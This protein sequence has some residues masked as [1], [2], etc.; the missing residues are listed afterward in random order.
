MAFEDTY[1][2]RAQTLIRNP[3][4]GLR[5]ILPFAKSRL[6]PHYRRALERLGSYRL[7]KPYSNHEMLLRHI[8]RKGGFFVQC[9]GNDGYGNDPTYYLEK[10]LGWTGIIAE[11]LPIYRA[12]QANR[13][14]STVFNYATGSFDDAGK[15]VSFIDCYGMSFV[16]GS[17]ENEGEWTSA[18]ERA[19]GIKA[20][21][22]SVVM[23]P[24]QELIEAYFKKHD[25][26]DIDLFVADVE[27]YELNSLKG[28]DFG[29]NP[30]LRILLEIQNDRRLEEITKYLSERDYV[31][32]GKFDQDDYL[33][34]L[35]KT[36]A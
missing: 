7:S 6:I 20:K 11:P 23:K 19:Q 31:T 14:A 18:G 29:K 21:T 30:P 12:C 22:I 9:G 5:K 17:I 24:I 10:A 36:I 28:L 15:T 2:H 34:I 1:L 13:R 4:E 32:E 16:K 35:K 8:D 26:R 3:R 33:F 25:R 27:G